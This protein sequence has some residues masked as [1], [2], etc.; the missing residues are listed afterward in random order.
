MQ[1][2]LNLCESCQQKKSG[3]KKDIVVKPIFSSLMNSRCQVDLIDFHSRS[4]GN[5]KYVLVY[6]E[7]VAAQIL[8]I[9]LIFGA[10]CIL[11]SDN[12]RELKNKTITNAIKDRTLA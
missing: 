12:G 2:F 8:D 5:Y 6:Q 7:E 1:I 11:Q 4:D 9:F 10:L 3:I